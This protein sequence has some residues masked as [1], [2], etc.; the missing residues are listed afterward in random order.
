MHHSLLALKRP[1]LLPSQ[2]Q[3]QV[4][5]L[6]LTSPITSLN[7]LTDPLLPPLLAVLCTHQAP[8][9][10]PLHMPYS[11]LYSLLFMF[12]ACLLPL[13]CRGCVPSFCISQMTDT[14]WMFVEWI[15]PD[16]WS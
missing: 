11:G 12:V 15:N 9:P 16:D 8:T 7:S 5:T 2:N 14:Q 1:R 6:N 3:S 13:E 4:H 10:G